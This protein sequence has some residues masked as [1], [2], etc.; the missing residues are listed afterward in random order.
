MATRT[1]SVVGGNWSALTAWVEGAVPLASDDVV[2][3]TLSGT[4]TVDTA[5]VCRSF[6]STAAANGWL[7]NVNADVSIG[8]SGAGPSNVAIVFGSGNIISGNGSAVFNFVGSNATPQTINTNGIALNN[9]KVTFNGSGSWK[10]LANLNMG[11]VRILT[12]TQG[13]FDANGFTVTTGNFA[14]SNSNARTLVMGSGVWSLGGAGTVWT[15]AASTNLTFTN[16]GTINLTDVSSSPKTFAGG[17]LTY[18]V[19]NVTAG[20]TGI[21]NFTGSNTY[22]SLNRSGTGTK[23]IKFTSGTTHTTSVFFA[24]T[25]GNLYTIAAVTAAS[26]FTLAKTGGG[27]FNGGTIDFIS[28]KDCTGPAGTNYA[29]AGSTLV[30]G[31]TNWSATA[32]PMLQTLVHSFAR[33]RASSY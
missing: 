32:P 12:L 9:N 24:G 31:N 27:N 22:T 5:S 17:G 8:D 15:F 3:T 33:P 2:A 19:V 18:G 26:A 21:L 29:G 20:G 10:L 30:S 23:S 11:S 25:A 7:M 28:L 14:G 6:D 16:P 13:T 1:I 4:L